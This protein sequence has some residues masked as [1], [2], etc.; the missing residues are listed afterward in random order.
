MTIKSA[1]KQE[2][3]IYRVERADGSVNWVPDDPG[4]RDRQELEAWRAAG[5]KIEGEEPPA[6]PRKRAP[7]IPSTKKVVR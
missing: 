4:N 2:S 1:Q 5:G 7:R 3:G 6:K